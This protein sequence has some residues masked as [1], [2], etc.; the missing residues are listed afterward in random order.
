M[1]FLLETL[2]LTAVMAAPYF[3]LDYGW[4]FL[5][6]FL[7]AIGSD[8]WPALAIERKDRDLPRRPTKVMLLDMGFH[9]SVPLMILAVTAATLPWVPCVWRRGAGLM[10][11]CLAGRR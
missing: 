5:L 11:L 6:G 2:A 4:A 9:Q 8:L 10:S 1:R 3:L 7:A